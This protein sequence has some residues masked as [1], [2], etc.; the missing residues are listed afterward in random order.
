MKTYADWTKAREATVAQWFDL[1]EATLI[2]LCTEP[3]TVE[4]LVWKRPA[5]RVYRIDYLCDGPHLFVTGDL[6]DAI[7]EAGMD[8]LR[9]WSQCSLDYFSGKCVASEYGRRYREWDEE[10]ARI[11]LEGLFDLSEADDAKEWAQLQE[12][13]GLGALHS[14]HDWTRW[15]EDNA[16][17][18][19]GAN[20]TDVEPWGIGMAPSLRCRGHLRGLQLAFAQLDAKERAA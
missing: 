20:W 10:S 18:V 13:G 1:N 6:G 2:T 5:S 15:L 8:G 12:L 17:Q 14:D 4:R 11:W 19:W 9:R 16:E 7:Y 3:L